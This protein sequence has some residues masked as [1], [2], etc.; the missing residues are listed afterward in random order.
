MKVNTDRR[1]LVFTVVVIIKHVR[2]RHLWLAPLQVHS[3]T[4]W[5]QLPER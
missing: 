3:A 1:Y 2:C 4:I 5:Q